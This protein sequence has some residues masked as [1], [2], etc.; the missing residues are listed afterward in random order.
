MARRDTFGFIGPISS[1]D[2]LLEEPILNRAGMLM[3]SPQNTDERLTDPKYRF[4][5]EPATYA[6]RVRSITYFR[7]VSPD[8]SQGAGAAQFM[9]QTLK[10]HTY[11][12]V[13]DDSSYGSS[14]VNAMKRYGRARAGLQSLGA[15]HLALED[16][17]RMQATIQAATRAIRAR[18]PDGVYCACDVSVATQFARSLRFNGYAKPL[19]LDDAAFEESRA[20]APLRALRM[21][22]ATSVD[23][24]PENRTTG[25]FSRS[26]RALFHIK[27]GPAALPA[28]E[29]ADVSLAALYAASKDKHHPRT[30]KSMRAGI[31]PYAAGTRYRQGE[32]HIAFDRNGDLQPRSVRVFALSAAGDGISL[33]PSTRDH[34]RAP[35]VYLRDHLVDEA[36][37]QAWEQLGGISFN[38]QLLL[39][40]I[41]N[42]FVR[43]TLLKP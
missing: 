11:Y 40:L 1:D 8:Q 28:Y 4:R 41:N 6:R 39:R 17:A 33:A 35:P 9:R 15:S 36:G 21:V 32:D 7:V 34:N 24:A 43:R 25:T 20:W 42:D 2:A 27:A 23:L 22:Y 10:L 29:A 26:Y 18:N 14:I 30:V 12:S 13:D 16:P 37:G 31:L 38:A 19:V 3:V 5:L